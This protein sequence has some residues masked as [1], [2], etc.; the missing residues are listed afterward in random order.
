MKPVTTQEYIDRQLSYGSAD[1]TL[2]SVHDYMQTGEAQHLK[3]ISTNFRYLDARKLFAF[4]VAENLTTPASRAVFEAAAYRIVNGDHTIVDTYPGVF[5][6]KC[7]EMADKG[8]GNEVGASLIQSLRDQGVEDFQIALFWV[9]NTSSTGPEPFIWHGFNVSDPVLEVEQRFKVPNDITAK[10]VFEEVILGLSDADMLKLLECYKTAAFEYNSVRWSVGPLLGIVARD[11]P[12]VLRDFLKVFLSID[13]KTQSGSYFHA[14]D[15][16]YIVGST[17]EFDDECLKYSEK[18]N[19]PEPVV[20][21][22]QL[23][24]ERYL[25]HALD[26]C[27]SYHGEE[28]NTVLGYLAKY[29]PSLSVQKL[30]QIIATPAFDNIR[31][32]DQCRY[33]LIAA[34]LWSPAGKEVYLNCEH[35]DLYIEPGAMV[36]TNAVS[37]RATRDKQKLITRKRDAL[38]SGALFTDNKDGE[39]DQWLLNLLLECPDDTVQKPQIR[40]RI[41][42]SKPYL[43]EEDLWNSLQS[44]LKSE[45]S[46][47][48]ERLNHSS[49][50]K[51]LARAE[52]FLKGSKDARLGAIEL[53]TLIADDASKALL[54]AALKVKQS[55][56]VRRYLTESLEKIGC[57]LSAEELL[58]DQS[59]ADVLSAI[60]KA[61]AANLPKSTADWLRLSELPELTTTDGTVLSEKVIA[62]IVNLQA[63]HKTIS[64][65]PDNQV[66]LGLIDQ[67]KSGDF[68]LALL[69]QW[70]NSKRDV[71]DK[72]AMTLAGLLGDRRILSALTEPVHGWG[73]DARHKLAEYAVQAVALAPGN[74]ALVLLDLLANRYRSRF[75]N[76]GKACRKALEQAAVNQNVSMDELADIIVP[77]LEFNADYQRSLPDTN[78]KAVL[79]P[80]FKITYFNP[81]TDSETK[82][83]PASLPDA[84]KVE[85]TAVKKLITATVKQQTNRLEQAMVRQR[86]W[87]TQRWQELF[88]V[89]PFL[90]SYASRLV[91]VTLDETGQQRQFFR[92]Y[93]NGL[94]ANAA[95]DLV[96]ME[97]AD[98]HVVIAHPLHFNPQLIQQWHEHLK[99]MKIKP[100]FAQLDRPVEQLTDSH[101][102]R[103]SIAFTDQHR[104]PSG[105]LRSRIEKLGWARGSGGGGGSI[106][107]YCKVYIGCGV[108]VF[109]LVEDCYIGQD[110]AQL[111]TL[112]KAMFV[113]GESEKTHDYYVGQPTDVDAK[114]VITF[115]DVADV[116]YSETI[117]DLHKVMA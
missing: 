112:G 20:T 115:G 84:A 76:I 92:R 103:K 47:A 100:P 52:S 68:A 13:E 12:Q 113:Q 54:L 106:S 109:L 80:D 29:D 82:T 39:I 40:Q 91:W 107:S 21:L 33:C 11:R 57:V 87:S 34:D 105:T 56:Q 99:R 3:N 108:S 16:R 23:R 6:L 85:M 46:I 104:M 73:E 41:Q 64:V 86:P 31:P 48:S 49:I 18:N 93:P 15:W 65:A 101:G 117:T 10:N 32:Y 37:D 81:V 63:K 66:L 88:E 17:E 28:S 53:L 7:A 36:N 79:Q 55:V 45:R 60:E 8:A 44:K 71:K 111:V 67:A 102:N 98:S 95:G 83:V 110:P 43:L 5:A 22:A 94:L 70:L 72:W 42:I 27:M 116:V 58:G 51:K 74:D 96:E 25:K 69:M 24:G 1:V 26:T 9:T 78:I 61:K 30:Q 62:H 75:R 4:A 14:L 77:T 90:Q 59:V 114:N 19:L 50:E 89:N 2:V 97:A 35:K 38:V